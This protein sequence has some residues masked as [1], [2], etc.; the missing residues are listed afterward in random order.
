ML[1]T[2]MGAGDADNAQVA[3]L[4]SRTGRRKTLVR[5]GSQAEYVDASP[6]TA[7]AG[8]LIYASA[9]TLRAVRF[10]LARLEVLG[11]PV[12]VVENLM[13][14]STGAANYSISRQ[15][16]LVYVSGG[17]NAQMTPK[18]LVWVDRSG[19]EERINAPLRAYGA[20]RISPDGTRL[21]LNVSSDQQSTDIWIWDLRREALRRLTFG[22]GINGL[23]LWTPD[24]RRIIFTS[25]RT[26]VFNLYSQAVDGTGA[27]DRLTTSANP[28]YQTSITPDGRL[29]AYETAPSPMTRLL[30][31]ASPASQLASDPAGASL[32]LVDP[33]GQILFDGR[34]PE[35]SPDG[36]YIAYQSAGSRAEI[37]VRPYPR[38]ESGRWQISTAGGTRPAWSRSGRELFYL[39]VSNALTVAPVHTSG[40]AFSAGKPAKVFDAT[41]PT[42]FPPRHYDVSPDGQ[43]FLMLKDSPAGDQQATPASMI[44]V[45]N[46]LEELK[47]RVTTSGK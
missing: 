2:I 33:S 23:P 16:T 39:D 46:W 9:G 36:R 13:T 12:T 20:P 22:P 6:V 31:L 32:S 41:Y 30:R 21:A 26:G 1:F 17:G 27:A 18:S 40:S 47:Q 45:L 5:G 3:V 14:K 42:P 38:V 19:R 10:D 7:Q 29:L 35:F 8:Y 34:W 11:A 37:Y 25:N 24:G 28:Q 4:D 15:G 43:R 44:V